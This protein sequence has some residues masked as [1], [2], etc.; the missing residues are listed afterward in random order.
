MTVLIYFLR[1]IVTLGGRRTQATGQVS[2]DTTL[3]RDHYHFL[4]N[5]S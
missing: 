3:S 2:S 5:L 1:G 4:E